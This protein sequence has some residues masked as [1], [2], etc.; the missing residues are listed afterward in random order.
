LQLA[1]A[2]ER[3]QEDAPMSGT[4]K[5]ER[6]LASYESRRRGDPSPLSHLPA[7]VGLLSLTAIQDFGAEA[8]RRYTRISEYHDSIPAALDAFRAAEEQRFAGIGFRSKADREHALDQSVAAERHR[9][10]NIAGLAADRERIRGELRDQKAK[11]EAVRALWSDPIALL[12][13]QHASTEKAS[14]WRSAVAASGPNEIRAL[15]ESA[16]ATGDRDLAA[17]CFSRLDAMPVEDRKHVGVSKAEVADMLCGEMCDRAMLTCD[18][19]A[20]L[21]DRVDYRA[22]EL[23]GDAISSAEKIDIGS[24]ALTLAPFFEPPAADDPPAAA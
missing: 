24:R 20:L 11:A 10:L 6:G 15:L 21:S 13:R 12:V 14:R 16:V 19:I 23:A 5:I 22:R 2:D 3:Y 9:L 7:L 17:A 8:V 1:R 18:A 4:D